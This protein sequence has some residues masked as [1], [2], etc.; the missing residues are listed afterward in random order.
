[1]EEE[2]DGPGTALPD[3]GSDELTQVI[4]ALAPAEDDQTS[5]NG[6]NPLPAFTDG[7]SR[8]FI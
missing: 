7:S 2:V 8:N 5:V 4:S 1:M 6:M 3:G